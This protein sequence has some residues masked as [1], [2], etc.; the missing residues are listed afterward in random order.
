MWLYKVIVV[1]ARWSLAVTR[2]LVSL[3][4]FPTLAGVLLTFISQFS[5]LLAFFLPL[6]VIVLIGSSGIPR[7]FPSSWAAFD[8]ETL[9]VALSFS[10]VAFYVVYLLADHLVA[11]FSNREADEVILSA[12]KMAL[13]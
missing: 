13:F 8:R 12:R 6:K 10:A 7:Y 1:Y 5:R 11:V 4:F 9:V 3:T 2:K